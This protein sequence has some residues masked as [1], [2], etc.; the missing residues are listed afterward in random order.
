MESRGVSRTQGKNK[1]SGKETLPK[2]AP[3]ENQ[4]ASQKRRKTISKLTSISLYILYSS[5]LLCD[6]VSSV[7][8]ENRIPKRWAEYAHHTNT[9]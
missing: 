4:K 2:K 9:Q 5:Y 7:L 8:A 1:G 3:K 6:L